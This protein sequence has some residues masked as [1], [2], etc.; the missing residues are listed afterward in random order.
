MWLGSLGDA[1][2][3]V[4]VGMRLLLEAERTVGLRRRS[5]GLGGG[6]TEGLGRH[7]GRV[8]HGHLAIGHELGGRRRR[9]H[10]VT[11]ELLVEEHVADALLGGDVVVQLAVE[12]P[13]RRLQVGIEALILGRQVIV[14]LLVHFLVD[15]ILLG[16]AQSPACALLVN[17]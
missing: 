10:L 14:L 5:E 7:H 1:V 3:R 16:D 8:H 13:R 17:L 6:G 11:G 2:R 9:R 15:D 4:A 12:Q